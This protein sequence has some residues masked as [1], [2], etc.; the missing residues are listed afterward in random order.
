MSIYTQQK[1]QIRVAIINTS[2]S[3][4]REKEYDLVSI[5]EITKKVGIAKGTFYNFFP[6]KKDVL[7]I[8]AAQEFK[9]MHTD[10]HSLANPKK[11]AEENMNDLIV[12]VCRLIEQEQKL[13]IAFLRELVQSN[14]ETGSNG[15]FNFPSII[16]EILSSS[17]DFVNI[18][19]QN[20]DIKVR[21]INDS[22][23]FEILDWYHCGKHFEDLEKHLKSI[24]KVCLHGVYKKMQAIRRY[25]HLRKRCTHKL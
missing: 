15:E 8:W 10:A 6:S 14:K 17:A 25:D 5:D 19:E 24:V 7:L 18:G 22:I 9:Q 12:M 20:L 1:E 3:M 4:F 13:F 21:V 2:I 23:F 16:R 11:T